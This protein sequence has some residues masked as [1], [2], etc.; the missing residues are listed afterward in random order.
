[1]TKKEF[2]E[3][4][5]RGSAEYIG[6]IREM[7]EAGKQAEVFDLCVEVLRADPAELPLPPKMA[8]A[9]LVN[10]LWSENDK[11]QFVTPE[12]AA[13]LVDAIESTQSEDEDTHLFRQME[14]TRDQIRVHL[15]MAA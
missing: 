12:N 13:R 5:L 8:V 6:A 4:L 10:F 14:M 7:I 2:V 1:M 9:M 11:F 15:P 3:L